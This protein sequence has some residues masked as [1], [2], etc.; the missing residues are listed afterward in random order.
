MSA[1]ETIPP[2][3]PAKK[4]RVLMLAHRLPY[5]PDRGDRIRS[6][7]IIKLLSRHFD[8]DLACCSEDPVWLQHHQLLATMAKRVH[9]QPISHSYTRARGVGAIFTGQA[10]TPTSFFR[11]SLA[12][13]LLQWHDQIPFDSVFTYCSGM[14]EYAR[15]LTDPTRHNAVKHHVIDLVDVDSAKWHAYAQHSLPPM[16]WVYSIESSRLR[17]IESGERD[18]FDAVTVV[19]PNEARAYREFVG[20][21]PGLT[22]VGNGVD[23][24][25]FTSL[26]DAAA[27]DTADKKNPPTFCFVGVLNYKPNSTGIAWFV[28]EVMHKLRARV[29][30]ARLL[31]VGRHPTPAVHE[32][33]RQPGVTIIGSV[34]DV[35][36]YIAQSHAVIAPLRIA[37]GVQN[38]VLEAMASSRA[39]V[40]SPGAAKG[41]EAQE[42]RHYLLADTPEQWVDQL[43]RVLTDR[44]FR[45][46]LAADAREHVRTHYS[47]EDQLTPLVKLLQ[48]SPAPTPST[49]A[50][51]AA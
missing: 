45:E 7:Q 5:P 37:R 43:H 6:Y 28:K 46:K 29:P 22:V 42:G 17:R 26:P 1:P 3:A 12:D 44:A 4:R 35:R 10:I 34:P 41:I 32:L 48:N 33:G 50:S 15:I 27:G 24:D 25:Y 14:I 49:G 30:D 36:S 23:V 8:L 51:A 16:R 13:V 40:C 9:I 20:E 19:T 47:W 38:K 31:V 21:H 39:V 11:Q 2:A 18:R